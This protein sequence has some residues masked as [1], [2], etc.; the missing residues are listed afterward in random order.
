MSYFIQNCESTLYLSKPNTLIRGNRGER[1]SKPKG[2][3]RKACLVLIIFSASTLN[4][5]TAKT[6]EIF[7]NTRSLKGDIIAR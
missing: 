5:S 6:W 3:I 2:W 7:L 1:Y 4:L